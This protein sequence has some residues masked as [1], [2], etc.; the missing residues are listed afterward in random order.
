MI[1]YLVNAVVGIVATVNVYKPVPEKVNSYI[2]LVADI[3]G[4]AATVGAIVFGML[5]K[6]KLVDPTRLT[7]NDQI[8]IKREKERLS[9]IHI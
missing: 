2:V 1:L 5:D 9:L 4:V 6:K 8:R 3:V 7:D